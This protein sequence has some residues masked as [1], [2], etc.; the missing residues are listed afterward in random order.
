V[1]AQECKQ[2]EWVKEDGRTQGGGWVWF[3][4]KAA[5]SNLSIA[6]MQAEGSALEYLKGECLR[7]PK[8]TKFNEKCVERVN[9]KFVVHIRAAIRDRACSGG[10]DINSELTRRHLSYKASLVQNSFNRAVCNQSNALGCYTMASDAWKVKDITTAMAYAEAAC[11]YGDMFSCGF[12]GYFHY[13]L[14]NPY[15][16]KQ[17]LEMGCKKDGTKVWC[18]LL[19][20]LT[21]QLKNS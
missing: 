2:H 15:G 12:L 11:T 8:A 7:I 10:S 4:G 17:Y 19:G 13:K 3:P 16:A 14:Q 20:D 21:I 18:D 6:T 1:S 5:H 9:G